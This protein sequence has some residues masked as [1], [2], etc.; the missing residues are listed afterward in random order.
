MRR[1]ALVLGL[2]FLALAGFA[3]FAGW[4]FF[5]ETERDGVGARS[6]GPLWPYVA[7]GVAVVGLLT[8]VFV[9]LAFYSARHGYDDRIEPDGPSEVSGWSDA[10]GSSARAPR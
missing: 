3:L 7:G 9:W 5:T 2:T 8:L 6:L 1:H 4:A 10:R